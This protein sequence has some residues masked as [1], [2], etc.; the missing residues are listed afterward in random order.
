MKGALKFRQFSLRGLHKV[1]GEWL[2]LCAALNLEQDECTN[3]V[4]DC[5]KVGK[6]NP[7]KAT[8]LLSCSI[9][10]GATTQIKITKTKIT[11]LYETLW[12]VLAN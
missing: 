5:L 6:R 4:E 7:N 2:L 12:A 10:T 11:W 8:I 9:M 1:Q 3:K